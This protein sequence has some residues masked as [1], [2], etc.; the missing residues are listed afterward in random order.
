MNAGSG[1]GKDHEARRLA[2]GVLDRVGIGVMPAHIAPARS[3]A[4][5]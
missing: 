2:A 5:A 4:I 1:E 3:A